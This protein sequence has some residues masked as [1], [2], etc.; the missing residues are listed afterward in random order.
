MNPTELRACLQAAAQGDGARKQLTISDKT[1]NDPRVSAMLSHY[2]HTDPLVIQGAQILP[3]QNG[4]AD[5]TVQGTASFLNVE[6][7]SV[8]ATFQTAPDG[9]QAVLRYRLPPT[10][11]FSQSFPD[12]P[13]SFDFSAPLDSPKKSYLDLLTITNPTFVVATAAHMD[14]E[15]Q[16]SLDAGLNFIATM[17]LNGTLGSI[18]RALTHVESLPL[19]GP[20]LLPPA[21][22]GAASATPTG[23]VVRGAYP[24]PLTGINLKATV[25]TGL[26]LGPLKLEKLALKLYSPMTSEWLAQ[27][28]D[29]PP[30]MFVGGTLG[31]GKNVTMDVFAESVLGGDDTLTFSGTFQGLDLPSLSNIADLV[32]AD[33]LAKQLEPQFKDLG[34][35]SIE[36]VS[37]NVTPSTKSVDAV[38]LVVGMNGKK[39]SAL[40]NML[41]VDGLSAKFIV[42]SPFNS[43]RKVSGFVLGQFEI[44][45]L[46]MNVVATLPDFSITAD[47]RP[48]HPLPL[49]SLV[50]KYLPAAPPVGDLTVDD[51]YLT[52]QPGQSLSIGARMADAP[53]PWVID[54]GKGKLAISD[55]QIQVEYAKGAG[56]TGTVGGKLKLGDANLD[57]LCKVPGDFCLTGQ[58]PS[59]S[60]KTLVEDLCDNHIPWPAG[61]DITLP[62]S[63]IRIEKQAGDYTFLL[64][65]HLDDFGDLAF[66]VARVDGHWGCAAG[67]S[68]PQGWKLSKINPAL[69]A[70]DNSFQFNT[71]L[72][73]AS[74]MHDSGFTF[75]DLA[76]F[77]DPAIKSTKIALPPSAQGVVP[78]LNF[79]TE[80]ELGGHK[81][82]EL[83]KKMLKVSNANVDVVVQIGENPSNSL[84]M[85][86]LN[87]RFNDAVDFTGALRVMLNNGDLSVGALGQVR[88]NVHDQPLTFTG[89]LDVEENGAILAA[90]MQGVWKDAFG[91]PS[92]SLADL[93]LEL[94]ITWELDPTIGIAGT[95]AVNGFEG[96]AAILFDSV[97][98]KQTVLAGSMSDL[99][100]RDVVDTFA[101]KGAAIPQEIE[102]ALSRI[103]L[104]GIPLCT[105][106][107]THAADLDKGTMTPAV[108]EALG[109]TGKLTVPTNPQDVMLV[110]GKPGER[111]FLTDRTNLKH[112]AIVKQGDH[113]QVSMEVQLYIARSDAMIGQLHYPQGFR[114]AGALEC[115]DL[116]GSVLIDV[117]A[118]HGIV[119][120]GTISRIE[121]GE[122]FR[123]TG[124]AGQGDPVVSVA[125]YDSPSSK[126]PGPHCFFSG[127]AT[128]LGFTSDLDLKLNRSGLEFDVS[129]KLFNVFEADLH[130][131]CPFQN[132]ATSDFAIGA[133][134]KN[135]LFQ[136][137]KTQGTA[138][139]QQAT[140]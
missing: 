15:F 39:W 21:T 138:A 55:V 125:T 23:P 59:V 123:L 78:G 77:N 115:F 117:N 54:L 49:K 83:I 17:R 65:V 18:E 6:N 88:V 34:K 45:Q 47:V 102:D 53:N 97:D 20:I 25:D 105:I 7:V 99:S 52:A 127:A 129:A 12:L 27:F 3:A 132:F 89:E 24:W 139:I 73:V 140:T 90:T 62:A 42:T 75:P 56:T 134:M 33:D 80:M 119:V 37:V 118:N 68:L 86:S 57:V 131:Q 26:G 28:P 116:N 50:Q 135:D 81:D 128:L 36:S 130:A 100:L 74:S 70:L 2:Y 95:I 114:L 13:A 124:H 106:P 136:F 76:G 137:L 103:A 64:G 35:L 40:D 10:W 8:T 87:G 84:L 31:V 43:S 46:P 38:S 4:S 121:A 9:V 30:G 41:E 69:A 85:A 44:D 98:P 92:L 72:L 93:A 120:D 109:A 58:L 82:L 126:Y 96:S 11:K 122:Y 111:W 113:L 1:L 108:Q 61:F 19:C 101:G 29:Y 16:T 133:S 22:P 5:V 63:Q 112:Y 71:M 48:D 14:A 110:V 94:G 67:F 60:I 107:A 79:F 91:V 66:K 51:L 104:K 32:G